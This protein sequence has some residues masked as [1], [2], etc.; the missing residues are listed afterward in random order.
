MDDGADD[1]ACGKGEE[2]AMLIR[3][4]QVGSASLSF[5][6]KKRQYGKISPRIAFFENE[7]LVL[8]TPCLFYHA[9]FMSIVCFSVSVCVSIVCFSVR[10]Y[11]NSFPITVVVADACTSLSVSALISNGQAMRMAISINKVA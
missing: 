10:G 4:H 1:G 8:S 9:C 7:T 11:I 2:A 5:C 6:L 3:T